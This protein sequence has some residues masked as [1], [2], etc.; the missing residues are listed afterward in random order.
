MNAEKVLGLLT[1]CFFVYFAARI[2]IYL[3]KDAYCRWLKK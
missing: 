1:V 3:G 2:M